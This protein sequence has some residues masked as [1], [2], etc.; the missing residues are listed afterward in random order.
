MLF[1]LFCLLCCNYMQ[2]RKNNNNKK[3]YFS[4][5]TCVRP[6]GTAVV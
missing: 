3:T 2:V 4:R 6:G 1:A 5:Q